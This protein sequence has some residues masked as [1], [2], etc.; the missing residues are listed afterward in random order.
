MRFPAYILSFIAFLCAILTYSTFSIGTFAKGN[1]KFGFYLIYIDI[2]VILVVSYAIIKR[3]FKLFS[4]SE[5][6]LSGSKFQIKLV[7]IFSMLTIIPSIVMSIFAII[8]FQSGMDAWF[9]KKNKTVLTE[10][11]SVAK[12]YLEEHKELIKDDAKSVGK[13]LETRLPILPNDFHLRSKFLKNILA[14]RGLSEGVLLDNEMQVVARTE[15][16]LSL[17]LQKLTKEQIHE[18]IENE[19]ILINQSDKKH[20]FALTILNF[21]EQMFLVVKKP[22]DEKVIAHLE[23]TK[24][25][26]A[27]YFSVQKERKNLELSFAMLFLLTA[28][29]LV[30]SAVGMAINLASKIIN[31]I[32]IL[33]D[34]AEKIRDGNLEARVSLRANYDEINILNKTFNEMAEC[35]QS[36]HKDLIRINKALDYRIQFIEN[37][38]YSISSGVIGLDKN[39]KIY[40]ANKFVKN[41]LRLS[42]NSNISLIFPEIEQFFKESEQKVNT[43]IEKNMIIKRDGQELSLLL[44]IIYDSEKLDGFVITVDDLTAISL[45]QKK[46]AWADVARSVAHEIKNPLTPIKLAA[47]RIEKKYGHYITEKNDK[48]ILQNLIDTIIRHSDNIKRL[49][50]E[51]STF[52]KLPDPIKTK[53]D[54]N[55]ICESAIFFMQNT[56]SQVS[57]SY[58]NNL[59][60]TIIH[61]DENL[62]RQVINNL[63]KNSVNAIKYSIRDGMK[64]VDPR[65]ELT[66]SK[67]EDKFISITVKD[68]GPGFPNEYQKKLLQP[69]F[70]LT[71][72]GTGLGLVISNK[73]ITDHGG[74]MTIGNPENGIGAIV[75]FTLPC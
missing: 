21:Q 64:I 35:I 62:I 11:L 52:A 67:K 41:L 22:I 66:L 38:L 7:S 24:S 28:I 73:I 31:P 68:N 72:N 17:E 4:S 2:I 48:N 29:L 25:A 71:P 36:Q 44:R 58:K 13:I 15:F 26:V 57:F 8:F 65:I 5:K 37:V 60:N 39:R 55:S 19:V 20:I 47:E 6:N 1:T 16:G 63:L 32:S 61:C 54:I 34:R 33:I 10:S 53:N 49:V 69:Y 18:V 51:F 30:I 23:N 46:S 75:E 43:V 14:L 9:T 45:A 40:I 12:A 59:S 56:N 27:D 74:N 70:S 3:F 42:N 50:D